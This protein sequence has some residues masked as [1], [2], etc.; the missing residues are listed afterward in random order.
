MYTY[1]GVMEQDTLKLCKEPKTKHSMEFRKKISTTSYLLILV[2]YVL[3]VYV[4]IYEYST[5]MIYRRRIY[6]VFPMRY[7]SE[8]KI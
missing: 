8:M 4:D 3:Y 1:Y 6:N 5:D 7:R 2:R